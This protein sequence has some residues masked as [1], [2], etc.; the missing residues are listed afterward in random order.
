MYV[1]KETALIIL[2]IV[3]LLY[4]SYEKIV[5]YI[6]DVKSKSFEEGYRSAISNISYELSVK[7]LRLNKC[8][9]ETIHVPDTNTS[10]D[11]IMAKCADEKVKEGYLRGVKDT[12]AKM[13][14]EGKK[15]EYVP[16][17]DGNEQ[18]YFVAT[19]CLNGGR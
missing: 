2:V 17:S 3:L 16:V 9:V 14:Y 18:M 7:M 15:C 19:S 4:I 13:I 11:I 6:S 12:V 1:N 8:S 10:I 5:S